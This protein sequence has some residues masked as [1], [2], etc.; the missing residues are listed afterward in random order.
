MVVMIGIAANHAAKADHCG[1]PVGPTEFLCDEGDFVGTRDVNE[2]DAVIRDTVAAKC[3]N[4]PSNEL[5]N[6][7]AV[8]ACC[9]ERETTGRGREIAFVMCGHLD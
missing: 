6:D 8:E 5:L 1:V 9:N 2:V 7:E 3:I 4:G